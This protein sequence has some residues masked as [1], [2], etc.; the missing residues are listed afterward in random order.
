MDDLVPFGC[1]EYWITFAVILFARGMD[2]LSTW[3]ATPNMVLEG[4]PLAKRLGWR[5]GV[6][7]SLVMAAGFALW[8]LPGIVIATTSILVAGRNFQHAWLMRSMGEEAYRAWHVA[9]LQ[10]TRVSLYLFC[11]F[12]QTLLI[13]A[14]G[15]ALIYFSLPSGLVPAAI[16]LGVISYAVAVAFFTL[17]AVWRTRRAIA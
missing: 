12:S 2:L 11:L 16:G 8:P 7:M 17:L 15:G 4:N 14:V 3:V 9:R 6:V 5:W 10:E 1:T 13:G